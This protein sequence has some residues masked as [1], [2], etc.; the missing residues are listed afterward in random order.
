MP[1]KQPEPRIVDHVSDS[2]D[3]E[4][5]EDE[6]FNSDDE[7]KYGAFFDKQNDSDDDSEEESESDNDEEEGDGGQYMLDLL[8]Q[9][10]SEPA[11]TKSDGGALAVH[12][13]ESEFAASV[14]QGTNLTL[15]S[16]MEGLK[17]TKGF[18]DMQK[19]LTKVAQGK[20]TSA[21]LARVISDR[22]KRKV[23]YEEQTEQVSRWMDAVQENRQA[24]SLDF[25]PKERLDVTKD[26]LVDKFEPTTDFEK[27]LHAALQRAGQE[28]EEAILKREEEMFQD[29]D[30]GSNKL[31]MEEYKKRR[32]QMAKMRALMFYHEQKRHHMNKIKSK[33][34]RRIRKKQRERLKEADVAAEIDEDPDIVKEL[35][36][37]EEIERMKERMTLAHKNTSKWAKRVLKRGKNVDIDTRRAL[38]AQLKRGDDLRKKMNATRD[39][40]E[41]DD[42]ENEDLVH[43]ARTVLADTEENHVPINN[44]GLF[45]L[46]FMQRGIEAQRERAKAEARQLLQELEANAEEQNDDGLDEEESYD[47]EK[48]SKKAATAAEM[49]QLLPEGKLVATSLEFGNSNS[50]AVSGG[51]DIDLSGS[52]VHSQT[53]WDEREK[54][55][56]TKSATSE[57]TCTL[58]VTGDSNDTALT[59]INSMGGTK[60]KSST[61]SMR[62]QRAAAASNSAEE[63]NPWLAATG[64]TN[65]E[66]ISNIREKPKHKKNSKKQEMVDV[67]RAVAILDG[68]EHNSRKRKGLDFAEEDISNSAETLSNRKI[69]S[70]TQEELVQRA[71]ATAPDDAEVEFAKEKATVAEREDPTRKLKEEKSK[72]ASGWGSWAGEGVPAS[73]PPRKFPKQ[74]HP[75]QKQAPPKRKRQDDKKPNVIINEKRLKKTA[76]FQIAD[77]P[78]PYKSR[79]EYERATAGAVGKEWNV[80]SAL[81]DMTR[82]EVMTRAGKMIQPLSKQV[83]RRRPAAKF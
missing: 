35:E 47:C 40:D 66:D 41:E 30:L 43:T 11:S 5:D 18:R 33:K 29:D 82:P 4:I 61:R 46:S 68:E 73:K 72:T 70:L 57:H 77:I 75:P 54:E 19:T 58:T 21:P 52:G 42:D 74:L 15:D 20:S 60:S 2:D 28:D 83:K 7:R 78:Y 45:K 48:P 14:V 24:E 80:T 39:D 17:D 37:K 65:A 81:K 55:T 69:V 6:A 53:V 64:A 13:P 32:A 56:C 51:I 63:A 31:T 22:A 1:R 49:K 27:E 44:Q 62:P 16:L 50:I 34:Y 23:H 26:D 3:E 79:E 25:R 38:S 71:F 12:V 67:N 76:K 9:L 8:N 36:E 59:A 10:D